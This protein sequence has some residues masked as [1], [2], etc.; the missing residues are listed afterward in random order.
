MQ[1][2][3]RWV[4]DNLPAGRLAGLPARRPV[5]TATH[6]ELMATPPSSS[7]ARVPS[8]LLDLT[9]NVLDCKD[10]DPFTDLRD[11]S[12]NAFAA[13]QSSLHSVLPRAREH[14]PKRDKTSTPSGFEQVMPAREKETGAMTPA[15]L[16]PHMV[17]CPRCNIK[18]DD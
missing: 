4:S 5:V 17:R 8:L 3:G 18:H 9:A 1:H 16:G 12:W 6:Q 10:S 11:E 7:E 2:R 14:F 13:Q 15:P